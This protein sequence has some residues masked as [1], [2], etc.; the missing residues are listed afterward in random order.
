M[1]INHAI[2]KIKTFYDEIKK[3][4]L[5]FFKSHDINIVLEDDAIDYI[6]EQVVKLSASIA[7]FYDRMSDDLKL[8]L[9]LIQEKTTK[10]RFFITRQAL[11][12]P[13]TFINTL[14]KNELSMLRET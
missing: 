14:I 10:N 1:D 2:Q 3:L 7:S 13:E 4:E 5:S 8:G 6:I 12:D 9:K 11:I